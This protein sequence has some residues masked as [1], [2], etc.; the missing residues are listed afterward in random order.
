MASVVPATQQHTREDMKVQRR[1]SLDKIQ[2][3]RA[4]LAQK[5]HEYIQQRLAEASKGVAAANPLSDAYTKGNVDATTH[6]GKSNYDNH[7]GVDEQQQQQQ[8][9]EAHVGEGNDN[10]DNNNA[11]ETKKEGG[12]AM[13][14]P[15]ERA[16]KISKARRAAASIAGEEQQEEETKEEAKEEIDGVEASAAN[17]NEKVPKVRFSVVEV[18]QYPMILGDHPSVKKGLPVTLDWRHFDSNRYEVDELE[19]EREYAEAHLSLAAKRGRRKPKRLHWET[20]RDYLISLQKYDARDFMDVLMECQALKDSRLQNAGAENRELLLQLQQGDLLE[21]SGKVLRSFTWDPL[22]RGGATTIKA[23]GDAFGDASNLATNTAV[24][25]GKVTTTAVLGAT[26]ATTK[27]LVAARNLSIHAAAAIGAGL[28]DAGN[29]ATNTA[30]N[31]GKLTTKTVLTAGQATTSTV[32]N[33]G[34]YTTNAVFNTGKLTTTAVLTAGQATTS[35][36]KSAGK[37]T[38]TAGRRLSN[39]VVSTG[40]FTTN[41]VITAGK[42][43]TSGVVNSVNRIN[44]G[45][46][47]AAGGGGGKVLL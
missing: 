30:L 36:V 7:E 1:N 40:K 2:A 47:G 18:R 32:M 23:L 38:F 26:N 44:Q 5:R 24:N 21:A 28:N 37:A 19:E 11:E 31:A 22:V 29:L 39:A 16:A 33:A 15:S 10:I 45:V 4:S 3:V 12:E 25:A 14:G 34:K 9:R 27:Q 8:Q 42:A 17:Q 13:D 43:T 41:A 46:V 6:K 35:T 20:R